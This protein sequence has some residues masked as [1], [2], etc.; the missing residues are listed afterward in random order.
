[1]ISIVMSIYWFIDS[2][3]FIIDDL[4]SHQTTEWK[5]FSVY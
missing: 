2:Y 3:H 1:M 4:G 5:H